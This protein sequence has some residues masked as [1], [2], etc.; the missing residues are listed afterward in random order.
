MSGIAPPDVIAVSRGSE[1]IG[2]L[3]CEELHVDLL[4]SDVVLPAMDGKQLYERLHS[5]RP[6]LRVLF[7]S[8]YTDDVI[9]KHGVLERGV[10][11]LEKPLSQEKLVRAVRT[12]LDRAVVA[13]T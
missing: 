10:A 4:V 1:A 3:Q 7:V 8:G 9:A 13:A 11:F 6:Q 5:M 12:V 2:L